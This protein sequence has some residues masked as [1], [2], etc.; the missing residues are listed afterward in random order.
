MRTGTFCLLILLS[1]SAF[2]Q[3]AATHTQRHAPK[4][5]ARF[6]QELRSADLAFAKATAARRLEGW[7]EFFAEDAAILQGGRAISGKQNIRQFYEPVFANKDF[8]LTWTPTHAEA[9]RDGSMG[10]TYGTYEARNGEHVSHGMYLTIWRKIG[11]R[12]LVVM[13]TGSA[14]PQASAQKAD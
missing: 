9:P 14:A 4:S 8:S 3:T 2:A 5:H 7:M 6:E 13:D 10:Y 1:A 11:G 12:W